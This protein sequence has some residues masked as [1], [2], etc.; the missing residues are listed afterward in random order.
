[1][2]R[3]SQKGA[4]LIFALIF[5]LILSITAASLLFLRLAERPYFYPP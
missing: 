5:A 3:S 4:A 1:M 2:N